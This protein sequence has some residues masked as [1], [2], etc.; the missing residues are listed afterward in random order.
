MA[1]LDHGHQGEEKM[2]ANIH[3][4]IKFKESQ[5]HCISGHLKIPAVKDSS[6]FK[7]SSF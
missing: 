2:G 7:D 4:I 1:G 5:V 3:S 6:F